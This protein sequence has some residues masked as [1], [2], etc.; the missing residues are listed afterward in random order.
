MTLITLIRRHWGKLLGMFLITFVLTLCFAI[1]LAGSEIASP[2]RRALAS[3]HSEFLSNPS[4]HGFQLDHFTASDGTPCLIC[5]PTRSG[6]LGSRGLKIRQ[7]LEARGYPLKPN[8]E[9]AGT[10]VLLHGRK[11]RKED[12]LPIAE[13]LCAI[14]FRCI[15]PDLPAHGDHPA[16]IATYGIR[17]AELPAS[18]LRQAAEKFG[19]DSQP[20]GL[21]GMSMG[22]S[23]AVHSAARP[24]APWKALVVISS[25]DS[26]DIA[27]KS[28]ASSELGETMGGFLAKA[29]DRIYLAQSGIRIASI[30]PF[31]KAATLKLPTLIAQ[32]D[33]DETVPLASGRH[34]FD[35]LHGT[36]SKKWVVIPGAT[37]SNVLITRYPIYAEI[38]EWMLLNVLES[39]PDRLPAN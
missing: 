29:A 27:I 33:S 21:L 10:L 22:G 2:S 38:A 28:Q 35:S 7:E 32:G 6:V 31:R 18:I 37:H 3:Y 4:A 20:A 1:Y 26:L 8:G 11:G 30:Q 14:G 19:F 16:R 25:F 13:R 5:T 9:I 12:Y 24:A 15:L 23:I 36:T 17:E 34:L 39:K